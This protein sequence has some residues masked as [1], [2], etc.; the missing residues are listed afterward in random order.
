M[1]SKKVLVTGGLG[2][3]GS[4]TI[5][6]LLESGYSVV[7]IDN[8][9][10]SS[11]DTL[12][13]IKKITGIG[14][15]N[16]VIDLTDYDSLFEV[17]QKEL[18]TWVI[19][20]A[21]YKS[22]PESIENP[23]MY[24]HNNLLGLINLLDVSEQFGLEKF[25]FSSS[26]SVYGNAESLP[27]SEDVPTQNPESP[28]GKTKLFSEEIIKDFSK[29]SDIDFVILRYFNPV[30]N[31]PSGLIGEDLDKSQSLFSS[32]LKSYS[33]GSKFKIWGG[34]YDTG[35][36]TA[37]RDFVHVMDISDA[38]KLSIEFSNRTPVEIINLGSGNPVSVLEVVKK[39]E[40]KIPLNWGISQRREGDVVKIWGDNQLAKSLLNWEIKRDIFDMIDSSLNFYYIY[41]NNLKDG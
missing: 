40:L 2:Y 5:I 29:K 24:Y 26:C 10:N 14:I 1:E 32:I 25:I 28:Y 36:G 16:Y 8:L 38:H 19:H 27:V 39:F 7:S 17:Y 37:I 35:D 18:P 6:S 21:A 34:D 31:H 15:K 33:S 20:F 41:K 4:H 13:N 23:L 22:V 3:I 12:L 11:Q 30:G 9:S